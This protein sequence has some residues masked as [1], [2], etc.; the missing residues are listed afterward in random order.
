MLLT[1][2]ARLQQD[3]LHYLRPLKRNVVLRYTIAIDSTYSLL[4][5]IL[6]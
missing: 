6:M 3:Y 2:Q 4:K 1:D 5:V